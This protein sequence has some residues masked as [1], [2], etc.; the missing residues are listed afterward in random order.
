MAR[1]DAH[2]ELPTDTS[3]QLDLSDALVGKLGAWEDCERGAAKHSGEYRKLETFVC[4]G[5]GP[6]SRPTAVGHK[7]TASLPEVSYRSSSL[8]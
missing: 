8:P 3:P 7:S 4:P 6:S 5:A 2:G 1:K